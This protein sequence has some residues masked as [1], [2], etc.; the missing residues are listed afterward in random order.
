MMIDGF[1]AILKDNLDEIRNNPLL[2]FLLLSSIITGEIKENEFPSAEYKGL[3]FI[4]KKSYIEVRGSLHKFYNDGAHNYDDFNFAKIKRAINIL[5]EQLGIVIDRAR[6]TNLEIGVNIVTEFNPSELLNSL[7]NHRGKQ[8][9]LQTGKKKEYRECEH[10]QYYIKIYNKGLQ[11]GLSKYILRIEVKFI[12]MEIPNKSG[13]YFLSD[14]L[15]VSK[16]KK[17]NG[18]FLD[19][20]GEILIGGSIVSNKKQNDRERLLIAN[21]HNP[22]YWQQIIPKSKDYTNGANSKEYKKARKKYEIQL[23]RFKKLLKETGANYRKELVQKSIIEKSNI[24]LMNTSKEENQI[25]KLD[26]ITGEIDLPILTTK[27]QINHTI[28]NAKIGEIDPL[29]YSVKLPPSEERYKRKCKVTK[30]DLSMQKENSEFLC[31]TGI[32]YYKEYEPKIWIQLWKRLSPRW[33]DC[34]EKIQIQEV[35]HS[36]RN[37]Y[38]N[39]IHNIRRS[40]KKVLEEPALFNQF[41]LIRQDKLRIAGIKN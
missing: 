8:F 37:E 12:K 3:T 34:S 15:D 13:I 24:L 23:A 25:S 38:L 22:N 11:N 31:T 2:D 33:H 10:E 1:K 26:K 40:I 20:F 16:I 29:L 9:T 36:I 32:K 41:D 18:K 30:L 17:L 19:I 6:F 35:H 27:R 21:G 7:I 14:L 28:E 5:S 4:E 39:K